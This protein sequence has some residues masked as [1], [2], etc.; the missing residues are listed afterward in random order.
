MVIDIDFQRICEHDGDWYWIPKAILNDFNKDLN[1]IS[2]I[3]YMD[4]PDLFDDFE[5]KYNKFHTG[6][7]KT[8]APEYF[9]NKLYNE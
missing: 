5:T 7:C 4:A 8:L 2:G 6:G 3:E 1:E 9:K